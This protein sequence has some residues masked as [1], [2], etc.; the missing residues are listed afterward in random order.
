MTPEVDLLILGGGCAGLSLAMRLAELG[1]NCPRT[2]IL[3][4]RRH[5]V[6][7]RTWCFWDDGA[8]RFAPLVK[9]RWRKLAVRSEG[10]TA[11]VDCG[12]TPYCMLPSDAFYAAA[13][14]AIAANDRIEFVMG[15]TASSIDR[16]IAQDWRVET[17]CGECRATMV[18]DTRP[19]RS[20]AARDA[21]LWQSFEGCEIEC[22]L[23]TFDPSSADLMDFQA[24]EANDIRFTYVL[25][26][27]RR[28]ALIETTVFG[29]FPLH[30]GAL[31]GELDA[32]IVRLTGSK[33]FKILRSE[34]GALP[35]GH[36]K[37]Q[38]GRDRSCIRV[39]LTSGGAR[40]ST[41]Y[42]FQRIQRWADRCVQSLADGSGL[43]GHAP[44]PVLLRA[45]D[46]LFLSVLRT[47]PASAPEMF[48]SMFQ[49]VSADRIIRF[50]SDRGTLRD[51]AAVAS[52]LPLAPFLK[53]IPTA[54]LRTPKL[55]VAP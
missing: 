31:G 16:A 24:S 50:L 27:S 49:N 44:D 25:P 21:I 20:R 10:R 12:A 26:V 7:D 43:V 37:A 5:Y 36:M 42:A 51:Y 9:H 39:G 29:P 23:D 30:R 38:L 6:H 48:L 22:A 8:T 45:M 41:G 47:Q 52:A 11:N 55:Q 33:K 34:Y 13:L 28:R 35:M 18:V 15:S 2:R 17:N 19:D 4:P 3:E 54:F 32:A 40:A 46:R 14:D 1:E 53:E